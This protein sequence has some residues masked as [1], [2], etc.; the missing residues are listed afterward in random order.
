MTLRGMSTA[1]ARTYGGQ[2]AKPPP[3][4]TARRKRTVTYRLSL[5][6][7]HADQVRAW[8]L[9]T[10]PRATDP[11]VHESEREAWAANSGG[12][13]RA[14]RCGRRWG[15]TTDA[16]IEAAEAAAAGKLVGWFAPGFKYLSEA[17]LELADFLSPITK[18]KNK[19]KFIRTRTGGKIEFW[20]LENQDAGRSRKYDL[21]VIDEAAFAPVTTMATWE[22]SIKPTLFDRGGRALVVS[23]T[24]GA[25]PDNFFYRICN[26]PKWGFVTFHAPTWNNPTIPE[27]WSEEDE[28]RVVAANPDI[29]R[30]HN[31]RDA[32]RQAIRDILRAEEIEKLRKSEHPLVFAQEYGSEF[33]DWSGDDFFDMGKLLV[34]GAGA[35]VPRKCDFVFATIDTAAK[36]GSKNDGTAVCYWARSRHTGHPLVLLD[37]DIVQI[38]GDLLE[39]WSE[40]VFQNLTHWAKKTGAREGS[41][42]AWIEDK[43]TGIVLLQA[44]IRKRKPVTPIPSLLTSVGKDERAIAVSGYV[45]RGEVKISQEAYDK[46]LSYKGQELNHFVLQV[47]KFRIGVDNKMDDLLDTFTYGISISLG[48]GAGF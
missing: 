21:V 38:Q 4:R 19:D 25:L 46:R 37:W 15:K 32:Y 16:E 28:A 41:R 40:T 44:L 14:I 13:Y 31:D 23:N 1:R 18:A 45:Y 42:G 17:Y 48:N 10:D 6:P 12:R 9:K 36:T 34:D 2:A 22:R 7:M 47:S 43:S 33:V 26:E 3:V 20:S 35:P 5:P 27:A 11:A 24:K 8:Q 30:L 29:A 39:T